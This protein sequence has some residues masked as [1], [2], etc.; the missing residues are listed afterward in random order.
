MFQRLR[1]DP[2]Q[3]LISQHAGSVAS[4]DF[5]LQLFGE[6]SEI[7]SIRRWKQLNTPAP[8]CVGWINVMV[9]QPLIAR[10]APLLPDMLGDGIRRAPSDKGGGASLVPV[11]QM[12]LGDDAFGFWIIELE[13]S[14]HGRL[15]VREGLEERDG[16]Q[17]GGPHSPLCGIFGKGFSVEPHRGLCGPP[18][19]RT[20]CIKSLPALH[21]TWR[22]GAGR[23]WLWLGP[24][25]S[26]RRCPRV[27]LGRPGVR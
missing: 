1:D 22:W 6:F 8:I 16:P 15:V 19:L 2:T 24:V 23:R 14:L 13:G 25:G 26:S 12:S 9:S 18:F 27:G 7:M 17:K 21:S 10:S 5:L 3:S 4:V 11:R 20:T